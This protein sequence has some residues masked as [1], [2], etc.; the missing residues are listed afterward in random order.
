MAS[1]LRGVQTEPSSVPIG[2]AKL[3]L[4]RTIFQPALE[5]YSITQLCCGKLGCR[6]KH[7]RGRFTPADEYEVINNCK[8]L[9]GELW[10]LWGQ[11]PE[12]MSLPLNQPG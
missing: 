11:R 1:G 3:I 5:W 12:V 9:E 8:E 10:R 6:D 4:L 7:H 2:H